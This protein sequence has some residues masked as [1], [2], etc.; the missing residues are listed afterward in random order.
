MLRSAS[1]LCFPIY[2]FF[3]LRNEKNSPRNET[4]NEKCQGFG[5]YL[6]YVEKGARSRKLVRSVIDV[7]NHDLEFDRIR[8]ASFKTGI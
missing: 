2:S 4:E 7:A 1:V 6:F 3:C 5:K 8:L